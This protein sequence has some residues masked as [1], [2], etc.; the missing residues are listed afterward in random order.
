MLRRRFGSLPDEIPIVGQGT[1]QMAEGRP[2]EG[3]IAALRAGI[4]RGLSHIDTAELYGGGAAEELIAEAIEG[5]RD[6]VFLVSKV[7]PHHATFE[8]TGGCHPCSRI[9]E[10]LGAGGYNA[11]RG[12]GGLTARV[13]EGGLIRVGDTVRVLTAGRLSKQEQE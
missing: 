5:R 13:V 10:A 4:A 9:E 11:M 1:W 6:E 3:E 7:L 8:G 2:R 12:H